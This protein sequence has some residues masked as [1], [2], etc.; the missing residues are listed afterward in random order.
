MKNTG[1]KFAKS[2]LALP[3]VHKQNHGLDMSVDNA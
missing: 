2:T 1:N 3:S